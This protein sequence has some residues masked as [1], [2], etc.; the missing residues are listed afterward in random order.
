VFGIIIAIV[1]FLA[2]FLVVFGANLVVGDLFMQ[3]R[4]RMRKRLEAQAI[5]RNRERARS[6][7][8][9]RGLSQ[10]AAEAFEETADKMSWYDRLNEMITQ[11]GVNCTVRKL[12]TVSGVCALFFGL[13]GGL[14]LRSAIIGLPFGL[15]ASAAPIMYIRFRR[16]Q[17]LE[18]LR[19]Q[20]P[21]SLELMSRTLRAG[22][23]MSQA[24]LAVATEFKAPIALE[25]GYCYEQQNLGL[26]LD[27]A[28]RDLAKRTGL[29][30][31]QIFVLG[32]LVHRKSGGN[33]TELLD[34]LS[35]IVRERFKIRGKIRA[36]T[37]EGRFQAGALLVL[38][39]VAFAGLV[40][41]NRPYA[42]K[43]LDHPTLI[44]VSVISMLFGAFWVRKI[45]NF[46]F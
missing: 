8:S 29:L 15:I 28:L 45:V 19:S 38:P 35:A 5:E 23:T 40:L 41:V 13:L 33:L 6:A 9:H 34:N 31:I 21:D 44:A 24:L 25:F 20:L 14:L 39:L 37:A 3:E 18:Q 30:E 27:V 32:L 26:S 43:L 11:S 22:E 16:G 2:G 1:A 17:R 36:M 42:L 7:I 46:D 10:L 12:L 4:E